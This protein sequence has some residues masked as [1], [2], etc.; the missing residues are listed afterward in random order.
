MENN[1]KR[2]NIVK[3]AGL[4]LVLGGIATQRIDKLGDT[5][6]LLAI[7]GFALLALF[8]GL[9]LTTYLKATQE[10]GARKKGP[11]VYFTAMMVLFAVFAVL[12]LR[13]LIQDTL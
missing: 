12:C 4:L 11:I 2:L 13:R 3:W 6:V 9:N 1:L 8:Q 5:Y 7:A 10:S